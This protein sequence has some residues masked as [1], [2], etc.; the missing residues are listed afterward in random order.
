MR[1]CEE[2]C[3]LQNLGHSEGFLCTPQLLCL[4]T[5]LHAQFLV[6]S[7]A[8]PTCSGQCPIAVVCSWAAQ[9][10]HSG[11]RSWALPGYGLKLDL[12]VSGKQ[13]WE[14]QLKCLWTNG[15]LWH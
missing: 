15:A 10:G 7:L 4:R 2:L 9:C 13:V 3:Y 1:S 8:G 12:A 11:G 5:E 6:A 14:P